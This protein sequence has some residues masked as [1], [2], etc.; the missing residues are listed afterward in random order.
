VPAEYLQHHNTAGP[1]RALGQLTPAQA[2]TGP[3]EPVNL[4]GRRIRH[5]KV[6]GGLTNE[7]YVAA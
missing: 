1:H 6:P 5:K 2:D 4:T 7:H 3:P